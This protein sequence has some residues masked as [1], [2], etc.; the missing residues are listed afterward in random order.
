V[1]ALHALYSRTYFQDDEFL[2]L[3]CPMYS[4]ESVS[5]LKR[6]YEWSIVD[7]SNIDEE[8]YLLSKKFSEVRCP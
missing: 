2:S 3:V 8:K 1:E 7:A 5:L 4:G 6:L